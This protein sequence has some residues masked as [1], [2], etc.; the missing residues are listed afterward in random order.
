M[1][2]K[3]KKEQ[4]DVEKR[5]RKMEQIIGRGER[6]RDKRAAMTSGE[7]KVLKHKRRLNREKYKA[8]PK[9]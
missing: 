2:Q 5:I 8:E 9:Y 4:L 7:K 3:P 1:I 6:Q